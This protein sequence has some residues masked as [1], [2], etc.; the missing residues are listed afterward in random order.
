M[1]THFRPFSRTLLGI[2]LVLG[3]GHSA[4]AQLVIDAPE[5]LNSNA[6]LDNDLD[7]FPDV[8]TDRKG[9]WIAVWQAPANDTTIDAVL[10]LGLLARDRCV[11]LKPN[12]RVRG[13]D[14]LVKDG[15]RGRWRSARL[16]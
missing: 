6:V 15:Q 11:N 2:A 10:H 3:L 16:K 9:V 13:D 5:A 4:S 1:Q 14:Q 12:D 7:S 8:A